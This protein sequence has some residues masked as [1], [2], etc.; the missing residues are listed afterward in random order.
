MVHCKFAICWCYRWRFFF[1]FKKN[2]KNFC[3]K[4]SF[5]FCDLF[6]Q[7]IFVHCMWQTTLFNSKSTWPYRAPFT[8][9]S[10]SIISLWI[11]L[12]NSGNFSGAQFWFNLKMWLI[13]SQL[14]FFHCKGILGANL[15]ALYTYSLTVGIILS[16]K[17][18]PTDA[19][20]LLSI[21]VT[22]FVK[23]TVVSASIKPFSPKISETICLV[24]FLA[25]LTQR[26]M[27]AIL[28]TWRPSYVVNFFKNL[29]L[30]KY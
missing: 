27:W 2:D 5:S 24:A 20:Y 6:C 3:N 13:D 25:H 11:L 18:A 1:S 29:L 17:Y 22:S 4:V 15:R 21:F 14:L 16:V 28:I 30:W 7:I 26:V 12:I 19:S 10:W 9:F 8:R 23:S